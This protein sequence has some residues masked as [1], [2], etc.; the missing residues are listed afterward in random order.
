MSREEI[1]GCLHFDSKELED[2]TN[3]FD[4]RPVKL[5][6]CKLGEGGFGP[7]FRGKLRFTEVA[8]KILR[9]VPK[10]GWHFWWWLNCWFTCF[11]PAQGDAGAERLASEQ[12]ITEV[13]VLTRSVGTQISIQSRFALPSHLVSIMS[14]M[15]KLVWYYKLSLGAGSV[16]Q[17][18]S[19]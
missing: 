2:A 6:G 5:G 3:K 15:V 11:L 16:T 12:F 1:A 9:N 7:V 18:W 19:L 17:T 13:K 14:Q 10:V 4:R 8:I